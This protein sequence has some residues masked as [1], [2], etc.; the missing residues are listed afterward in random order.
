MS[1]ATYSVS[2]L[3]SMLAGPVPVA[4]GESLESDMR[5]GTAVKSNTPLGKVAGQIF[6]F[7]NTGRDQTFG[8]G[9]GASRFFYVA[10]PS[11]EEREIGC[12]DVPQKQRDETRT[13]GDP[14]GDNPRN[15]GA[16]LRGNFHPTVKPIELMRWLV[17]LI[18][19]VGGTVLD[20]FTGSGTTGCACAFELRPFVGIEREA[21]YVEIAKRRI[22]A[23]APL[24]TE[25]A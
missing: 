7:G 17:R 5:D 21:D 22:A 1:F 14:G 15:R 3:H 13:V 4:S 25:S 19:P 24:F 12:Y 8:G 23:C 9:G 20:P 6:K 16:Q 10:K 11:R 18:T 2:N